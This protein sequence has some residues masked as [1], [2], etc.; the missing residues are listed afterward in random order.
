[1]GHNQVAKSVR[2]NKN[3]HPDNY[4]PDPKCLWR[5]NK[6]GTFVPVRS[7]GHQHSHSGTQNGLQTKRRGRA[8]NPRRAGAVPGIYTKWGIAKLHLVC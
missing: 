4:C 5:T 7:M 3:L 2:E 8:F 1:M 6:R